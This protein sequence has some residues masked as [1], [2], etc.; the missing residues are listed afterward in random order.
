MPLFLQ[1]IQALVALAADIPTIEQLA[2]IIEADIKG[3]TLTAEQAAQV[4]TLLEQAEA[5]RKADF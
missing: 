4:Q 5:R 3:N 1:I 2:P